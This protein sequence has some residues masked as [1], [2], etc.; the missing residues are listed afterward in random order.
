MPAPL[1]DAI[2]LDVADLGAGPDVMAGD[3]PVIFENEVMLTNGGSARNPVTW[4]TLRQCGIAWRGELDRDQLWHDPVTL[5]AWTRDNLATYWSPWLASLDRLATR[6]DIAALIDEATE[7][8]VL[9][10]T[11]LHYTLA[12]GVVTS[13]RGAGDYA[14]DTFSQKWHPIV[15][16]AIRIRDRRQGPSRFADPRDAVNAIRGYLAMVIADALTLVP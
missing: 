13:K 12:T 4:A 11:R 10:V 7:W 6:D 16:E 2:V 15:E 1:L 9:G 14:L 8:G 5:N 3:R